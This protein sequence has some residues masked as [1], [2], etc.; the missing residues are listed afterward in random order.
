[1]ARVDGSWE[2]AEIPTPDTPF[3]N[4]SLAWLQRHIFQPLGP[5]TCTLR[6]NHVYLQ[7]RSIRSYQAII[8]MLVF[9]F[10]ETLLKDITPNLIREYQKRRAEM[11]SAN[12]INQQLGVVQAAQRSRDEALVLLPSYLLY[13]EADS[14]VVTDSSFEEAWRKLR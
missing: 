14:W 1:M 11:I 12:T 3:M 7:D 13:L 10:G 6:R 2:S 8:R 4:A 5:L 9:F